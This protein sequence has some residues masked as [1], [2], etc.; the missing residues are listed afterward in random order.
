MVNIIASCLWNMPL[1]LSQRPRLGSVANMV[2][3]APSVL[4]ALTKYAD[5]GGL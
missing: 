4:G 1:P 3:L 5:N 2:F